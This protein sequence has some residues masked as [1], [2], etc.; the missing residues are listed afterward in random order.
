MV[1][2]GV[3]R[4]DRLDIVDKLHVLN[5]FVDRELPEVATKCLEINEMPL[6][7]VPS[8]SLLEILF[9]VG[10]INMISELLIYLAW[11]SYSVDGY[12]Y[13]VFGEMGD[14]RNGFPPVA[15]PEIVSG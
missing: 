1:E 5:L 9:Q 2:F 8:V 13:L 7:L 6:L 14:G 11:K 4:S 10:P 12:G 15:G 3:M